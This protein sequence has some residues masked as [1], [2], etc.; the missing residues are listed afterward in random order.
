MLFASLNREPS[1]AVLM[2]VVIDL[3][4]PAAISP[5][6]VRMASSEGWK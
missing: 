3:G 1:G 4:N 2:C 5:F 6:M